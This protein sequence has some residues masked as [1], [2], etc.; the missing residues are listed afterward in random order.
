MTC[1]RRFSSRFPFSFWPTFE[2]HLPGFA[3]SAAQLALLLG[4]L[5]TVGWLSSLS[6][7]DIKNAGD[8]I[9]YRM[10]TDAHVDPASLAM[11]LQIPLGKYA[12]R[13]GNDLP[14]TLY[15][16]SKLWRIQFQVSETIGGPG[17]D[18]DSTYLAKYAESSASGWTSSLDWFS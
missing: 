11:Q 18:I 17:G 9:D 8:A 10:R 5:G 16:S 4:F 7:Q 6:A 1:F 15:Y 12:G 2:H 13:D 3:R 14:I